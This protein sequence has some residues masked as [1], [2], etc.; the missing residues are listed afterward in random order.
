MGRPSKNDL[1]AHLS[2]RPEHRCPFLDHIP[3]RPVRDYIVEQQNADIM[4][5]FAAPRVVPFAD[6][7]L[8]VEDQLGEI[9]VVQDAGDEVASDRDRN[10][11][12]AL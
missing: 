5:P 6:K 3:R 9:G 7:G 11:V 12:A 1:H 2:Q 8:V 4:Q 10:V